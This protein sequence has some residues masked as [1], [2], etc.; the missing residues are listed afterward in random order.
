METATLFDMETGSAAE[1]KAAKIA[2][3]RRKAKQAFDATSSAWK[4]ATYKIA[5]EE[6]LPATEEFLFE[7]LSAYYN[8]QTKLR[9]LPETVN[10]KAFAGLQS[11]LMREGLIEKIVGVN[12][13]RTNGN[14][15]H[16]YRSLIFRKAE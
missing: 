14:Q 7:E 4:R 11:R 5:T 1:K 3:R 6:F 15:G 13:Y 2:E 12:P 16:Y 9:G 10:G 8:G